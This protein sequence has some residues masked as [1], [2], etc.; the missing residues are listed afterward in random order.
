M[1]SGAPDGNGGGN[2]PNIRADILNFPPATDVGTILGHDGSLNGEEVAHLQ[3]LGFV[4]AHYKSF[5]GQKLMQAYFEGIA[6]GLIEP[7]TKTFK[8]MDSIRKQI[9]KMEV[10]DSDLK[11]TGKVEKPDVVALIKARGAA[12]PVPVARRRG[13]PPGS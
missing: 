9:G 8:A 10:G 12:V 3:R 5:T 6:K 2:G 1:S 4:V 7:D 13:R 11:D